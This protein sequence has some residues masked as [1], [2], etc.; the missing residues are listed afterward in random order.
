MASTGL[1]RGRLRTL[2]AADATA[3]PAGLARR[4]AASLRRRPLAA[5]V[6]ALLVLAGV[7]GLVTWPLALGIGIYAESD[8]FTFFFPVFTFLHASVKAGELP[9]WTPDIFGGFPLLAEGQIG[10]LYPPALA[11]VVLDPPTEGFLLLRLF[12]IALAVAGTYLFTRSLGVAPLGGVVGALAFGLGSFVVGQQHHANLLAATAWLPLLLACVERALGSAGWAAQRMIALAALVLG[13]EA[14]ATHVQP[15]MLSGALLVGYVLARQGWVAARAWREQGGLAGGRAAL[16]VLAD[17]SATLLFVCAVGAMIAA[18]QILPLYEL[19]QE[20]WRASGWSYQDATEYSLPPINLVTLLLPFFFRTPD[21]GQWSLWQAWEV[22]VYVGVVPLVLAV[23]A[24]LAVRRWAVTFFTLVALASG[25]VSLG[26]YAPF[27]LYEL[28]WH[29]PGMHL[30]R[31]PARFTLITTLALAVLAAHGADWLARQGAARAGRRRLVALQLTVL[32]L[33]ALLTAHLAIWRQWIQQDRPWAM[34]A[35]A[36]TYLRLPHDP[37][38]G[39]EP[40]DVVLGLESAL[41]LANPKTAVSLALLAL[42]AV[43]LLAWRELPRAARLWQVLLVVL[44]AADLSVFASDFHPLV[45]VRYLGDVGPAGDRL[46]ELAGGPGGQ[47]VLTDPDVEVPQPNELLPYGVPEAS[48]YSPLQLE[49][50]RWYAASVGTADN[51]LLD[52]WGVRWVV[53]TARPEAMPSYQLVSYHP[54]RPLLIGG[55]ATPNG[56]IRFEHDAAP[57][58]DLRMIAA[59]RDGG[60]IPDGET[61]GEWVL[62]DGSGVRHTLP[63]RAGREIADWRPRAPGAAVAHRPIQVAATIPIDEAGAERRALGYAELPLPRRLDIV[64]L[65]YRHINPRG[66][67]VLYGVALF[68]RAENQTS[69]VTREERYRP[70]YRDASVVIYENRGA[71]PRVFVAPEAVLVADGSAALARL[72]DGPL[73]PRRQV[74][75]ETVPPPGPVPGAAAGPTSAAIVAEGSGEIV[76]Q[77]V[78]PTGGYLVMTDPY[79][80]GWR[81]YV[82]DVEVPVLRADYLFRAVAL[83]PGSHVV[84]FVFQP[85]VLERGLWLSAGGAVLAIGALLVGVIGPWAARRLRRR[86]V[87][88]ATT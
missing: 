7:V 36:A 69:Q 24:S 45:D 75:L 19:S 10:A 43:L 38:L 28:L 77:T 80:P 42:F 72:R 50:H 73:D 76:V 27:G 29:V 25:L 26:G 70:V 62:T 57:A 18:A 30:Q 6:A 51:V 63:V 20:S 44:V 84:R 2:W 71:Y 56:R 35:L 67:T 1:L 16:L 61:V 49:R 79:Y 66:Q 54:R 85:T 33:L 46:V 23:V 48:G 34:E 58:T 17:A 12:H 37:L 14:L 68:D 41:D 4:L 5:D 32:G 3:R 31:A 65:E 39:L 40:L 15:L 64:R 78:A 53:R 21:G 87:G 74:V 82:D 83:E 59:L 52:L 22:V 86:Q 8:T 88:G 47:R 81:A 60:S 11:A 9:L 13:V 55:A